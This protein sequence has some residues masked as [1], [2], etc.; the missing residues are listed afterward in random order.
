M[1]KFFKQMILFTQKKKYH[2]SNN[3]VKS[4]AGFTLIELL[5]VIAIIGM[6]SSVVLASLNSARGKANNS[7][8]K[9]NLQNIRAQAQLC[10]DTATTCNGSFAT[11][12]IDTG[13]RQMYQAAGL[14][15]GGN[16]ASGLCN[17]AAGAWAAS[18]PLKTPEGTSNYW[19]VDSIGSSKGEPSAL[20]GTSCP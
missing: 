9:E 2:H 12:C 4:V 8:V 16:V 15:G 11:V 20:V 13:V 19:C 1:I 3:T 14:A 6:L 10:Y 7:A 17:N 18:A 5:V